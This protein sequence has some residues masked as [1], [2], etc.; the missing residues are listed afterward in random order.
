MDQHSTYKFLGVFENT[1]QEDKQVLEAAAKTYLQWLSIIWSS[2][3]SDHA[4]VVA[5]NQ[6]AL[7]VLTYLMWTLTWPAIANIQQLQG[8]IQDFFRGEGCTRLLLYF[9][10]NKTH[11]FF[12]AEYNRIQNTHFGG[13]LAASWICFKVTAR[14]C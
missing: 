12:F 7:P 6:Y 1:K 2:P 10:T 13:W 4:K 3:L 5:S 9:N 8:R 11:S 14:C